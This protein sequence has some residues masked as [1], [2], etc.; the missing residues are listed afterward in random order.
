MGHFV[1]KPDWGLFKT[2]REELNPCSLKSN[3]RKTRKAKPKSWVKPTT[4]DMAEINDFAAV[5]HWH[6]ESLRRAC[7]Q[8][9]VAGK[10]FSRNWRIPKEVAEDILKN[11][12]PSPS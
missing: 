2:L 3:K 6:P 9:R 7:R 12:I 10:K 1:A 8:G 11:G 4:D 5:I